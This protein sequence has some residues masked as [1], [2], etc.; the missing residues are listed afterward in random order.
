MPTIKNLPQNKLIKKKRKFRFLLDSA[1]AAPVEFPKF[2]K[3]AKLIHPVINLGLSYQTSDEDIYQKAVENNC[4]ILTVNFKDFRKF[5]KPG[6]PGVIGINSQ[7]SNEKI[8]NLISKFISG[9]DPD[10]FIG[11]ATKI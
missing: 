1:F 3:K 8:D 5:V 4:F 11:K 6:K 9:K 10:D 7:L 2:N